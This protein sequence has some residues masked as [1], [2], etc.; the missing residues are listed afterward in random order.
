[1]QLLFVLW[2]ALFLLPVFWLA[3]GGAYGIL[4]I[5]GRRAIYLCVVLLLLSFSVA[6]VVHA[7]T[8][9][10]A[11]FWHWGALS[12][13]ILLAIECFRFTHTRTRSSGGQP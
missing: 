9:E 5:A 13:G 8:S 4:S 3:L 1:M 12:V 2:N 10:D 11:A 7:G 6:L